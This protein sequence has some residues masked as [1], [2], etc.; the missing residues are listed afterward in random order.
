MSS[1]EGGVRL[2]SVSSR[3]RRTR[4][5]RGTFPGIAD[6]LFALD[7]GV[8]AAFCFG[9]AA[10]V[11]TGWD[12]FATGLDFLAIGLDFLAIGLDF[13][14]MGLDRAVPADRRV[15]PGFFL[16]DACGLPLRLGA[17]RLAERGAGP[18]RLDLAVVARLAGL[19]LAIA[20]VLSE[21]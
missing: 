2:V 1:D 14:A 8:A 16:A 3:V 10:L 17:A 13:L 20:S 4:S 19:R 12:R 15:G 7:A 9:F 5:R 21:P 11:A 18:F 6:E